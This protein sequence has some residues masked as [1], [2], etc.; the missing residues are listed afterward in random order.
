MDSHKRLLAKKQGKYHTYDQV[1][2][3]LSPYKVQTTIEDRGVRS[4]NPP[5]HFA[6]CHYHIARDPP[7]SHVDQSEVE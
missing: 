1:E 6:T 4:F 2:S 5:A 3:N 7:E